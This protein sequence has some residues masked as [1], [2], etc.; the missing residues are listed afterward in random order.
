MLFIPIH[1]QFDVFSFLGRICACL[2]S[3]PARWVVG[4]SCY[5]SSLGSNPDI[6]QKYKMGVIS[7][8]VAFTLHILARQK[9]YTK[10]IIK[11][12]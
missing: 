1:I 10:K 7:K 2:A 5:S 12:G 3:N 9:M 4:L 6:Y 8:G 11:S